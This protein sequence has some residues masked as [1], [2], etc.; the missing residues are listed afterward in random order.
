MRIMGSSLRP[1]LLFP[2]LSRAPQRRRRH[3]D[4]RARPQINTTFHRARGSV[5]EGV[6]SIISFI[7]IRELLFLS[8]LNNILARELERNEIKEIPSGEILPL[9]ALE[10]LSRQKTW[11]FVSPPEDRNSLTPKYVLFLKVFFL[12]SKDGFNLF[13]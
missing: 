6:F 4:P 9:D 13:N 7:V 1:C 2:C 11:T 10:D 5:L 12:F 8:F 3:L